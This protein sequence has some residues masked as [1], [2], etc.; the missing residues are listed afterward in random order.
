MLSNQAC[1][2]RGLIEARDTQN[3]TSKYARSSKYA[4][5]DDPGWTPDCTCRLPVSPL[6][7]QM[8]QRWNFY[9]YN[10]IHLDKKCLSS[11]D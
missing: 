11:S 4:R 2:I 7:D 5:G 8:S 1:E 6:A 9:L 3:Y 10:A